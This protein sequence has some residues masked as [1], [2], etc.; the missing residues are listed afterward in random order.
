MEEGIL[1]K[2]KILPSE[3]CLSKPDAEF[4]ERKLSYFRRFYYVNG[5]PSYWHM[6][7]SRSKKVIKE[8]FNKKVRTIQEKNV[9]KNRRYVKF[10]EMQKKII[11]KVESD[12]KMIAK[13][14]KL[15]YKKEKSLEVWRENIKRLNQ[16]DIT[17]ISKQLDSFFEKFNRF[18]TPKYKMSKEGY[19]E[20]I[21][22][23]IREGLFINTD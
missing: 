2:K 23:S 21:N 20:I 19:V 6:A 5:Y 18:R 7:K 9:K 8:R 15:K 12:P 14:K 4:L 17:L 1:L 10:F 13:I 11:E 16:E 3:K 22:K